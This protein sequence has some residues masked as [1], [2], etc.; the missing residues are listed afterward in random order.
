MVDLHPNDSELFSGSGLNPVAPPARP[1]GHEGTSLREVI[2]DAA[3]AIGR[4]QGTIDAI[5]MRS[6]AQQTACSPRVLYRHFDGKQRLLRAARKKA[7][8]ELRVKLETSLAE[9][10]DAKALTQWIECYASSDERDPWVRSLLPPDAGAQG[11]GD[12]EDAA[13]L[14]GLDALEKIVQRASGR[15]VLSPGIPPRVVARLL[16][17]AAHG[18]LTSKN[19]L[20]RPLAPEDERSLR[21]TAAALVRGLT[22]PSPSRRS[23]LEERAAPL[24]SS[25][26]SPAL[27]HLSSTG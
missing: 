26:G 6:L 17:F 23:S 1:T 3:L 15:E 12:F 20:A 10:D 19:S 14:I 25:S 5:T 4:A 27:D 24:G 2:L 11:M 7:L 21:D 9:D 18:L 22:S 16:W 13:A 8:G